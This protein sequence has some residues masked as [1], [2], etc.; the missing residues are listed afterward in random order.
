MSLA[1][2]KNILALP[3]ELQ[4]A[5]Q[6]LDDE[7]YIKWPLLSVKTATTTRFDENMDKHGVF[8]SV[9]SH[10]HSFY[11]KYQNFFAIAQFNNGQLEYYKEY[12]PGKQKGTRPRNVREASKKGQCFLICTTKTGSVKD[13]TFQTFK[14]DGTKHLLFNGL[15]GKPN[16]DFCAWY[17]SG[18]KEAA[19]SLKNGVLDGDLIMWYP[20]GAVYYVGRY[21]NGKNVSGLQNPNRDLIGLIVHLYN[22]YARK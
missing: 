10:M 12:F 22:V 5:I 6:E 19:G 14:E 1:T 7:V 16:G 11:Y 4:L 8:L 17:R 9:Q 13:G 3:I 20:N 18:Q 21:D 2:C 15:G